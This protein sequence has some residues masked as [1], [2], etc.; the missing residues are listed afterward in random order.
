MFHFAAP[1]FLLLLA[2]VPWLIR[3]YRRGRS[4]ALV[5]PDIRLFGPTIPQPSWLVRHGAF[6][7]RLIALTLLILALCGPRWP[8]LRTRLDTEGVA[9]M[10]VLDVSGSMSERDFL[11]EGQNV[12]RLEAVQHVFRAFV[13]GG[14]IENARFEGRPADLIGLVRFA[15]RPE[16]V[17]PPTLQHPTL[18]QLLDEQEI[19]RDA[20]TNLPDAVALALAR[21][22]AAPAKRRVL[23]LLT[24]GEDNESKN[25]SRWTTT[26]AA[27][28][29]RALDIPIYAI[30]PVP[31]TNGNPNAARLLAEQTLEEMAQETGGRYARAGETVALVQAYRALD[32]LE[33]VPIASFQYRR[34][35][36][37]YPWLALAAL[38]WWCLAEVLARTRWR[39]VPDA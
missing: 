32:R 39:R 1:W 12:S 17:C 22:Q 36:E 37:A 5:H 30:D 25:R 26:Q 16:V 4:P 27:Q 14:S 2:V 9:I 3:R 29:A 10:L 33:R 18:L 38:G 28:V 19:D 35:H 34:Y 24:D 15:A 6:T 23:I 11:L 7:L 21:L 20:G 31:P 13:A 8:D